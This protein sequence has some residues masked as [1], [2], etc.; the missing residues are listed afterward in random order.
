LNNRANQLAHHLQALGVKPETK[1]GI[2][3]ERC[4]EMLVGILGILKAGGA[5]VPIDPEY[6]AQRQFFMLQDCK[7]TVLLTQKKFTA[8]LPKS[9]QVICLDWEDFAKQPTHNLTT[10]VT[11]ENLAYIIY[12]SGST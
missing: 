8:T 11:P 3:I 12:T 7:T 10:N 4:L 2:C 9:L 1:V 6:P 5:Y